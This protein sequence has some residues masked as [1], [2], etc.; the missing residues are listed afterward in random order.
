M[1]KTEK[2]RIRANCVDFFQKHPAYFRN[3]ISNHYPLTMG[4]LS[5]YG[6]RLD[7]S[8][9]SLNESI[10]WSKDFIEEFQDKLDWYYLSQNPTAF[11]D[12]SFLSVFTDKINWKGTEGQL[13]DSIATNIGIFWDEELIER[14]ESMINFEKISS[15]SNVPWSENLI[16]KYLD[17][18]NMEELGGN[19]SVPWT[20]LLFDK[21]LGEE[22]LHYI[23]VLWNHRLLSNIDPS[24]PVSLHKRTQS[25]V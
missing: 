16:D 9:I 4:L 21:Y 17:R 14:Y 2:D 25:F 15:N 6:D 12:E 23:V 1:D 8:L 19:L 7:W 18:W 22:Y 11:K 24:F 5:K 3:Q 10:Q 20:L 13:M